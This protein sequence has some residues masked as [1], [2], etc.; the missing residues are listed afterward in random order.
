MTFI[1][2]YDGS[3]LAKAALV[4]GAEFASALEESVIAITVIPKGNKEYAREKDWI[5]SDEHFDIGAIVSKIHRQVVGIAPDANFNHLVV[6]RYAKS[7]TISKRIRRFAEEHDASIVIVGS[8]NAGRVVIGLNSVGGRV[9]HG[10]TY[11]IL[12][13]RDPS[14]TKVEKI[15][16]LSHYELGKSDFYLPG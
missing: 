8:K 13:V 15:K 1:V 3:E 2:P 6:D 7:G 12:I 11:D 16:E 4:R 5:D 10:S 9:S 14:P